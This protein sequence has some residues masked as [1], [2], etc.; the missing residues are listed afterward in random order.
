MTMEMLIGPVGGED[1]IS[2]MFYMPLS[3]EQGCC[4]NVLMMLANLLMIVIRPGLLLS[5]AHINFLL[6][7]PAG[8]FTHH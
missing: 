5:K 8:A 2:H 6:L 3:S 7:K 1:Y 4:L